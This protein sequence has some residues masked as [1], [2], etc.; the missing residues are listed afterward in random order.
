M[1]LWIWVAGVFVPT[2]ILAVW[3]DRQRGSQ[4]ES[5]DADLPALKHGRL[6]RVDFDHTIGPCRYDVG[7]DDWRLARSSARVAYRRR[8]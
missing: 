1:G 4:G 5:R 7:P 3:V 2:V 6:R 8:S